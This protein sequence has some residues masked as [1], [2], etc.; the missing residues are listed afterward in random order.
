MLK[1]V[2]NALVAADVNFKLVLQLRKNLMAKLDLDSMAKGVN[3]RRII[4]K[5]VFDEL[6][7]LW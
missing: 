6:C 2:G 3:K 7:L 4:E 5:T 1:E